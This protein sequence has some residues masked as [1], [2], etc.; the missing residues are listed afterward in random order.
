VEHRAAVLVGNGT[1][2]VQAITSVEQQNAL[3]GRL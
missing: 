1:C 3:R 2:A